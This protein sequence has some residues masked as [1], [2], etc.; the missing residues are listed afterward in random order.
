MCSCISR[1][2]FLV[3][4]DHYYAALRL[5]ADQRPYSTLTEIIVIPHNKRKVIESP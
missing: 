1:A 2:R 4:E 5:Q 3:G